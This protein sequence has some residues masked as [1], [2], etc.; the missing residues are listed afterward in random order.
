MTQTIHYTDQELQNFVTAELQYDPSAKADRIT[1]SAKS[2][3]VKLTGEAMSL[4]EKFAAKR[5]A[6]RVRG[7]SA[8]VDELTV[9][10]PGATGATD[11]DLADIARKM[12]DW[13]SDVPAKSVATA[14]HGHVLTLS[15]RVTWDY[16]R[17]AAER[18]VGSL[19]GITALKNTIMLDQPS[20][21]VPTT[22]LVA[23]AIKRCAQLDAK[24]IHVD[25][26]DHEVIL[27]GSVGSFS[28]YRQAE[29]I[30]WAAPGVTK[31]SNNLLIGS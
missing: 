20:V 28:E 17:D 7:V 12:L 25:V 19:R 11:A 14:V 13:A 31:V 23:A 29:H 2:G 4:S 15:G 9:R 3:T 26:K 24:A 16:Q 1:V 8:V 30:A 27:R 6:M 21:P 5:C 10:D 22:D 18:I